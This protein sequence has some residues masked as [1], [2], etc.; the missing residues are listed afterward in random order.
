MEDNLEVYFCDICNASVPQPDL[1]SGVALRVKG[2][3]VGGCCL[4]EIREQAT[5][6]S[7]AASPS[8]EASGSGK[9]AGGQRSG[10]ASVALV[11][12]A[13]VAGGTLF[14]DWRFAQEVGGVDQ[15][16]SALNGRV[17]EQQD[18][19]RGIE[20]RVAR[21][22]TGGDLSVLRG[23]MADLRTGMD[24]SVGSLR[25]QMEGLDGRVESMTRGLSDVRSAQV[26]H[27]SGVE[28]LSDEL[29]LLGQEV[30]GLAAM[31]RPEPRDSDGFEEDPLPVAAAEA[32][33]AGLPAEIAHHV[34]KLSDADPGTRFE[35][36]DKL[37]QSR[38][39]AVLDGLVE[40]TKDADPFVRRLTVEGLGD[41]RSAVSVDA[42]LVALA[43]PEGIVRDAAYNSLRKLTNQSIPFDP[44]GKKDARRNAQR[45]WQDWWAKNRD[46]F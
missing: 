2:R 20:E 39:P 36:V 25:G 11:M 7:P 41:F 12:V 14:L 15:R 5:G 31:P 43:D 24:D 32:A 4:R 21:T 19:L 38:N 30:A 10:L 22:V 27:M 45:R 34:S 40:M 37:I 35:A 1:E 23:A 42:L 46:T 13:A 8:A 18:R 44:D 9:A 3:V 6:S 29:R 26:R 16:M 17:A 28:R 33:G